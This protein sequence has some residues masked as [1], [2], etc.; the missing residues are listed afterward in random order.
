MNVAELLDDV[1]GRALAVY[2]HPDD[3]EVSCAGTLCRWTDAGAEVHLVI[4]NAGDKGSFDPDADPADLARERAEEVAAAAALMGL[5]GHEI[6]GYPDGEVEN[7]AD[8]RARLVGHIRAWRPDVVVAPD[9][10]AVF[11]AD[12]YVNHH[13]HRAV[14]WAT[15]DACAPMAAHPLYFPEAGAAHRVTSVLL[16]GTL[17]PD[18]WVDIA[19]TLDAKVAA[20]R[21]HR[22]QLADGEVG[23]AVVDEIVRARAEEAGRAAGVRFAEGFR[24][25]LL[26][27]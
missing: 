21:C 27:P 19:E 13:D 20:V 12:A 26:A 17:D 23:E 9:P 15:L 16:S 2:A 7:T 5:A 22:S 14:G 4:C 10:T 24:R 8:V 6:L 25:L 18:C 11:F 3:P 1:P